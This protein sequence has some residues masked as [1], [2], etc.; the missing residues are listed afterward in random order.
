M[1]LNTTTSNLADGTLT[2]NFDAASTGS[3]RS[4]ASIST[5]AKR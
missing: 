2:L 4:A 1:T 5:M 3:R